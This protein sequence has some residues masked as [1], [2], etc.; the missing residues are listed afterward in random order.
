MKKVLNVAIGGRSFII[1]DNAYSKLKNYLEKFTNKIQAGLQTK[2][3]MED[4]EQRIA[5]LFSEKLNK[6]RDVINLEIVNNVIYQ[7]GMPDGSNFEEYREQEAFY[8][9]EPKRKLFRDPNNKSIG[10]V[11]SGLALFF[12][13]DVLAMRI[14]FFLLLILG[15]SGFWIYLILWIAVPLANTPTQKCQMYGWAVTAENLNKVN[16]INN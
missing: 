7:L 9:P 8:M 10:G 2:E 16:N 5:E 13:V 14:I 12:N 11:C 3:V 4:L 15:F 1:D 6:N